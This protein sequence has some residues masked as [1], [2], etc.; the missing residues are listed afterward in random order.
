MF[1]L[2]YRLLPSHCGPEVLSYLLYLWQG[3]KSI[4]LHY[5]KVTLDFA[6]GYPRD[7]TEHGSLYGPETGTEWSSLVLME[8]RLAP[9]GSKK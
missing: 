8:A 6:A 7:P 3:V 2:S 5:D 4:K 1:A 9:V